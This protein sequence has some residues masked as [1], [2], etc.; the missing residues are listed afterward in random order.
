MSKKKKF[1]EGDIVDYHS[2][3]GGPVT[4]SGHR[5]LVALP[6]PNNYGC[7]CAMIS[8]KSGVVSMDALTLGK[9]EV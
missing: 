4:S 6:R 8:G 3:V 7:D 5:V 1:H 9:K 2:V